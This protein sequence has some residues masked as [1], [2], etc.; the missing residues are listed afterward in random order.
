M[1]PATAR[2]ADSLRERRRAQTRA[3]IAQAAMKLFLRNG[4]EETTADEIAAAAGVSRA[5]FFNYFPQKELILA[6]FASSR[7]ARVEQLLAGRGR[8]RIR[9]LV[10]LFVEFAAENERM[11]TG[12]R[13]LFPHL[14]ARPGIYAVLRPVYERLISTIASGIESDLRP[15]VDATLFAEMFFAVYK[16]TLVDWSLMD[17]PPRGWQVRAMEARLGM[18]ADLAAKRRA[19]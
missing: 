11:M 4:F 8:L 2:E 14:F 9:D 12:S 15:G 18:L 3:E 1:N 7:A 13:G 10:G 5:T 17:G 16:S 6:D 19:K